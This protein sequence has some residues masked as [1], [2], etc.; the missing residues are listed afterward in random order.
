M[1]QTIEAIDHAK[2]AKVPIIVAVNKIDLPG[3]NPQ[4]VKDGLLAQNIVAEEYGG[5]TIF[6]EISAK[7]NIGIDELL[8]NILLLAEMQELTANPNRLATGVVLEARLDRG[9]GPKATLLVQNGTLENR[10]FVVVGGA[11][12]KIRRMTNEY[13]K[14]LKEAGPSTPVA[15][16]GLSEVPEAGD[17]FMAFHEEKPHGKSLKKLSNQKQKKNC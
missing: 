5:D 8:D 17:A 12:G 15:I 13:G 1:P 7:Q 2:A 16:I 3:A 6:I 14:A 9:E 4:R 10:D 11:Y